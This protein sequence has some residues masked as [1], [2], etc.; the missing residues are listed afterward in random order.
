MSLSRLVMLFAVLWM[1]PALAR[2]QNGSSLDLGNSTFYHVGGVS[3]S[4]QSIGDVEFYQFSDGTSGMRNQIGD[5]GF[6]SSSTPGLG[7]STTTLGDMTFGSWRDGTSNTH[8]S[9]GGMTFHTFSNGRRCTSTQ[10]S[11]FSLMDCY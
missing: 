4:S 1:L 9:I 8:Q 3:G 10:L 2:A 7:G 5:V 6:Y 11:P